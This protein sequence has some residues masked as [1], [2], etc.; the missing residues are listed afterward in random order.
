M[1]GAANNYFA[2]TLLRA[3]NW[4]PRTQLDDVRDWWRA[5]GDRG[6]TGICSLIGIGGAGK[7]AIADRFL[8]LLPDVLPPNPNVPKDTSLAVPNSVFVFSFYDAPNAETFLIELEAWLRVNV[9]AHIIQTVITV[10]PTGNVSFQN[11]MRLLQ[12]SAPGLLVL[13]GL[14]R[15]Q[16]D[17]SRGTIFGRLSD[18]NLRDFL[19][20]LAS[21]YLPHLAAIITSRF[22]LAD[23]DETSPT[24]YRPIDVDEIDRQTGIQLLRQRGVTGSEAQLAAIVENC[25]H[26]ALTVDM[27][28]GLLVE[29]H[30]GDPTTNLAIATPEEIEQAASKEQDPRRRAVL[31]QELRFAKVAGRYRESLAKRD[32]AALALL[33]RVC[34]FR[35]GTDAETLTS[36]FTGKGSQRAAGHAL[37]RLSPEK[38]QVKLDLLVRM[39]LLE[40]NSRPD[41]AQRRSGTSNELPEL[42]SAR[43]GLLTY[44]IHPAVR[45]GFRVGLD[46]ETRKLGH[47]A[48]REGLTA[49]LGGLPGSGTNPSDPATLD[50]LE[51]IVHHTLQSGHVRDAWDI[52][53]NRIGGYENLGWRLGAYERGERICRAFAGGQSPESVVSHR[54]PTALAAGL[55]P[56]NGDPSKPE[57]SAYGS[58]SQGRKRSSESRPVEATT[59]ADSPEGLRPSATTSTPFLDLPEAT[60]S[61]FINEWALYLKNLG[62]LAAAARCYELHNEMRM[63]QEN[64]KNASIGNQNLCD[65]LLLSGRLSRLP[66]DVAAKAAGGKLETDGDLPPSSFGARPSEASPATSARLGASSTGALATADE[67]LRLAELADDAQQRRVSYGFRG[68]THALLGAAAAALAD[69]RSDL[70]WQHQVETHASDRPL[71]SLGGIWHTSLLTRFGRQ[72]E[73]TRLTEE[74]QEILR[75]V[76]G[77]SF[78]IPKCQLVLSSLSLERS[79]SPSSSAG[80]S[81]DLWTQ[82]RDW[83]LARDAKEVLCWSYLVEAQH[84]F[85]QRSHHSP[86]DEPETAEHPS[87]AAEAKRHPL[88]AETS[89]D[90]NDNSQATS[91]PATPHHS[92]SDGYLAAATALESGLKIARNCGYGLY[93]IDLLIARAR[94]H[95]ITGHPDKALTDI[96]M[97]LGDEN[98]EGG[99]IPADDETGQ[100]E[101]LAARDPACGYAW[102]IP[103]GLQLKAEALLL[104]AA[105][106]L[107]EDSFVPAKIDDLPTDV[108]GSIL[109]AKQLLMK[110]LELWQ[111]LHDPEPERTDQNYEIEG[112]QYNYR[113]EETHQ[114]FVQLERGLLTRYPVQSIQT[115]SEPGDDAVSK[116]ALS[117]WREKLEHL[118]KSRAIASD[119]S[120]QFTL[121]KQI[122]EAIQKIAELDPQSEESNMTDHAEPSP[123][124]KNEPQ[125]NEAVVV[126]VVVVVDLSRYS[127]IARLLQQQL[128]PTAVAELQ[129]QIER[130]IHAQLDAVGIDP[131]QIPYESTGDGAIIALHDSAT[132]S[133]FGEKLHRAAEKYNQQR[134]EELAQRHFRVGIWSDNVLI[135]EKT[136]NAGQRVG[137]KVTGI[138]ISNA[139][140][141]EG[142]CTTGEV[143]IGSDA[144]ADLSREDR[145]AYGN[146][147]EVN[148]KRGESFRVHRR[149]I[150][151]PAPWD[152]DDHPK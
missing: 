122:E 54:E 115:T 90:G 74:N 97:A 33:E 136:N 142:A 73:A 15:I 110:A 76:I 89:S 114:V 125:G 61:I 34:L 1:T 40:A 59:G 106:E 79:V 72:E 107:G 48:A 67:A 129:T 120:Q 119:S 12:H 53:K 8:Q 69:F 31:K 84:A 17:G 62:R 50:L 83:A 64:W 28:G 70:D 135:R 75:E 145:R 146:E 113:A 92:E 7:T 60:Q 137:L 46:D 150:V 99:G 128:G 65:V 117:V 47:E 49:S 77:S 127:D 37:S 85:A 105:Q 43:S 6:G 38:L 18:G 29:F 44:T 9:P 21:G 152:I 151:D 131:S 138:A 112:K 123:G 32:K 132:A 16:E 102:P 133:Q 82:A 94:L 126:K 56:D 26:H 93:H 57:A 143:L 71:W 91:D 13:D 39:G 35:L 42:R 98:G 36:I 121:D 149:R 118:R 144:W 87:T 139:V 58:Q 51:E 19:H 22:P 24:W 100:P 30:N 25:G 10:S 141:L 134:S 80:S 4:Q 116:D 101:L 130:L 111:P 103:E 81:A 147:E 66:Q 5:G 14:E 2:H 11:V 3:R 55:S 68:H 104:K 78:N 124:G 88:S 148:G 109:N 41:Q 86:R 140:R 95:L 108:A 23:L 27:A 96:Q 20:R 63:R 45:D 52:Y